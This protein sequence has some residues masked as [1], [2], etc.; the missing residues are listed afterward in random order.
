[1]PHTQQGLPFRTGS[2]S[3]YRGALHAGS[4]RGEKVRCV[5]AA[6]A[7]AG[8]PGLLDEEVASRCG[9]PRSSVCS[10]RGALMD[11]GLVARVGERL[12]SYGVV[13]NAYGLTAAGIAAWRSAVTEAVA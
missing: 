6:Y 3:S 7:E 4:R 12:G 1:V 8:E 2:H 13:V 11:A 5:F 9:L 10:L